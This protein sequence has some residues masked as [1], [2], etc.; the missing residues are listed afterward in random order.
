M[1]MYYVVAHEV[2]YWYVAHRN[3]FVRK[4]YIAGPF[5]SYELAEMYIERNWDA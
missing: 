1:A 4:Y 5:D 3:E 2:G